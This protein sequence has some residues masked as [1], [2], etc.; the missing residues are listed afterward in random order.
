MENPIVELEIKEKKVRNRKFKTEIFV[1]EQN[2]ILEKF[3]KILGFQGDTNYIYKYV[4]ENNQEQKAKLLELIP[5]IKKYF[6][7]R[8]WAL[9]SGTPNSKENHLKLMKNLYESFN[10]TITPTVAVIEIDGQKKRT[11]KY[12]IAKSKP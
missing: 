9:A 6:N 3:N 1:T 4:L 12:T 11:T 8:N 10:Y 5:D 2:E 7:T